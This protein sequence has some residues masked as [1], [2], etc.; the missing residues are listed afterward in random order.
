MITML[1]EGNP[2]ADDLFKGSGLPAIDKTNFVQSLW[3]KI[4]CDPFIRRA[5]VELDEAEFTGT[6]AR[7]LPR[8]IRD[9]GEG[10]GKATEF[11]RDHPDRLRGLLSIIIQTGPEA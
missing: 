5:A 8:L 10:M 9:T 1:T 7:H 2:R 3:R 4:S 11:L 6:L